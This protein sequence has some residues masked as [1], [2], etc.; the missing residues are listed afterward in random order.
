MKLYLNDEKT[1]VDLRLLNDILWGLEALCASS[2]FSLLLLSSQLSI[3]GQLARVSELPDNTSGL[4]MYFY[5][6]F[7]L[8]F[9]LA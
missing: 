6:Y 9:T 7:C 5:P 4:S 8:N 3:L 1:P 2:S